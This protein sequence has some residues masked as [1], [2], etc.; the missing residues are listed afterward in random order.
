MLKKRRKCKLNHKVRG[1]QRE[2]I[3]RQSEPH[4]TLRGSYGDLGG[5]TQKLIASEVKL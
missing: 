1:S 4:G 3:A 5:L 2:T